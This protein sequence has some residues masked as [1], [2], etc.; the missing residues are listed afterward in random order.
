MTNLRQKIRQKLRG[1]TLLETMF[2]V[3]VT[4]GGTMAVLTMAS[5]S[6]K[7]NKQ[8]EVRSV[9]L[10][11]ARQQ[12]ESLKLRATSNRPGRIQAPFTIPA[13]LLA[14]FPNGS[15][16]IEM[17]GEYTI[18]QYAADNN[19]QQIVVAVRWRNVA[20]AQTFNAAPW[21]EVSLTTLAS[22]QP[23]NISWTGVYDPPPP[24]P[25]TG[26]TSA[27]TDGGT[28]G[29][30]AGWEATTGSTAG[31]GTTDTGGSGGQTEEEVGGCTFTYGPC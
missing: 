10:Q 11:A 3:F 7:V 28:D 24:D 2:G 21:S 19:L 12:I 15:G 26:S 8:T 20:S 29:S 5:V 14:Q 30:T 27:G 18:V 17:T 6:T 25:T 9:A 4:V 31:G 23:L 13:S 22:V 1:I 16:G